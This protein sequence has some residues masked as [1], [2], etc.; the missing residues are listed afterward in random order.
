M[1]TGTKDVDVSFFEK[2]GDG[3]THGATLPAVVTPLEGKA[4]QASTV[5]DYLARR[6]CE[7]MSP[8]YHALGVSAGFIQADM[9]PVLSRRAYDC[10][11]TYGTNSE[12]GF[13]Y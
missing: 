13:D 8:I 3:K 2:R 1:S 6:D 4:D 7:W 10:D 5:N 9:D 11:I 12:F